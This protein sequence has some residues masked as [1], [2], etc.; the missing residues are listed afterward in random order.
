[1]ARG[2]PNI[3]LS[4]VQQDFSSPLL[5]LQERQRQGRIDDSNLKTAGQQQKINQQT[6]DA[7]ERA[8]RAAAERQII[9]DTLAANDLLKANKKQEAGA[10]IIHNIDKMEELG[11]DTTQA[12]RYATLAAT[13]PDLAVQFMEQNALPVMKARFPDLFKPELISPNDLTESGQMVQRDR[14]GTVTATD[15]PGFRQPEPDPVNKDLLQMVMPTG[16]ITPIQYNPRGNGFLDMQG[17]PMVLPQGAQVTRVGSP[18]GAM[19]DVLPEGQE[20][21]RR[22]REGAVVT[23]NQTAAKAMDFIDKNRDANT[24]MAN[25]A[26][27]GAGLLQEA[28]ALARFLG[29]PTETVDPSAYASVFKELNIDNAGLQSLLTGLA[30]QAASANDVRGNGASNRDVER[31]MRM[32]GGNYSNPDSIMAS[33]EQTVNMIN[34]GYANEYQSLY[35]KPF[36]GDLGVPQFSG[37]QD[38]GLTPEERAEL[39]QLRSEL[40]GK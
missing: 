27:I 31:F 34:S 1:M 3:P 8:V 20:V 26:T 17:N 24:F 15:V 35:G 21:Q 2:N 18:T 4:V 38:G 6:I 25:V 40:L 13:R 23:F 36:E 19:S 33:L 32:I 22:R 14:A 9:M 28:G 7:N 37:Q 29:V 16:E 5:Q 11:I 39:E 10:L 12:K 30:Y